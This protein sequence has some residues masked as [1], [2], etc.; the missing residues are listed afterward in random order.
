M[1]LATSDRAV[2]NPWHDVDQLKRF[3]CAFPA[4]NPMRQVGLVLEN[5]EVKGCNIVF[6]A[7]RQGI[8]TK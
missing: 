3:V 2:A 8:E 6:V 1:R 4:D 5:L 7:L